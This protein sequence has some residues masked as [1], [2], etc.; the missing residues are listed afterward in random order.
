MA[1]ISGPA[2]D[3]D[4][5]SV[6]MNGLGADGF[7]F[8]PAGASLPARA[9]RYETQF[10]TDFGSP[11]SSSLPNTRGRMSSF[12]GRKTSG[13]PLQKPSRAERLVRCVGFRV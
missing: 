12:R 3:L 5:D 9:Q 13:N 1:T 10:E 4:L 8:P 2:N 11:S 7:G 6:G